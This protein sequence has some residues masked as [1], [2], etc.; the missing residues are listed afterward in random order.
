MERGKRKM[1][2]G[3]IKIIGAIS[4]SAGAVVQKSAQSHRE[5]RRRPGLGTAVQAFGQR[6][7][8]GSG[9]CETGAMA[10]ETGGMV[11]KFRAARQTNGIFHF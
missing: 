8:I 9:C 6:L 10:L 2:R 11:F 5:P 4:Q 3:N 7:R 1:D